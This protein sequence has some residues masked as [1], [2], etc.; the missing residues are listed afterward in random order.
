MNVQVENYLKNY[1]ENKNSI[2]H[3]NDKFCNLE[4]INSKYI[5]CLSKKLIEISEFNY[6]SDKVFY[7]KPTINIENDKINLNIEL[8]MKETVKFDNII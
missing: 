4:F 3:S 8:L 2:T 1:E 6:D 7:K 5:D